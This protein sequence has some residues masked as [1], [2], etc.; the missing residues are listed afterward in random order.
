LPGAGVQWFDVVDPMDLG[1]GGRL[2]AI[3]ARAQA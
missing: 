3:Q 1:L 2:R